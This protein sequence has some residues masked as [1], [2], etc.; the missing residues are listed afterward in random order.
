M[1]LGGKHALITGGSRGIGLAIAEAL[2][3]AGARVTILGRTEESLRAAAERIGAGWTV[4]D[5]TDGPA[6]RTAVAAAGAIDILV[7]NAGGADSKPFKRLEESDLRRM[8]DLNLMS[9]FTATQAVL[10]GM[11]ERGWGRVVN[12][13]ST[14]GQKGYA[15]VA[16]YCAAKH[17]VIGLTRALA[18]E[19][20]KSGVTVNAVCPGYADTDLLRDSVANVRAK[21]GLS[22][23]DALARM[24]AA[25]PQGRAV[26]PAEVAA[27]VLWLCGPGS[28]GITGQ[29][30]GVNGGEVT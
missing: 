30:I 20:A 25:V 28:S 2:A 24:L 7:N 26:A 15:Y 18:V 16:H 23:E 11:V 17:A 12:I 19:V 1:S 29:S 3:G 4:A 10:P 27:A 21:T 6:L 13:A 9:A 8:L 5:V 22:E 14:A